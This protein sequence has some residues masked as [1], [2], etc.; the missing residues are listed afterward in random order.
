MKHSK[1]TLDVVH[2]ALAL[3]ARDVELGLVDVGDLQSIPRTRFAAIERKK[4]VALL[5]GE[6]K[7]ERLIAKEL[8][9]DKTTV[10]ADLGRPKGKNKDGGNPPPNGGNPPS[11]SDDDDEVKTEEAVKDN[12]LI[13]ADRAATFAAYTGPVDEE[14]RRAITRAVLAW[15]DLA[16]KIGE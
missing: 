14:V 9:V 12:F 3:A 5:K 13:L 7:S 10:A 15:N 16:R 8:G 6:G 1:E 2:A 4:A 11:D